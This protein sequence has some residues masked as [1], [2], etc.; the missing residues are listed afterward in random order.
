MRVL[1]A[2]APVFPARFHQ[3]K[4]LQK[5]SCQHCSLQHASSGPLAA[6]IPQEMQQATTGTSHRPL[7]RTRVRVWVK[8]GLIGQLYW[9]PDFYNF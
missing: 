3:K 8:I 1:C 9:E 7:G 2:L 5:C 4:S 6:A